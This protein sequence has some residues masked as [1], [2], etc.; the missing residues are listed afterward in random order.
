MN[1][2]PNHDNPMREDPAVVAAVSIREEVSSFN[3][4]VFSRA[5]GIAFIR[6]IIRQAYAAQEE[7]LKALREALAP[8]AAAASH[9]K[10]FGGEAEGNGI[11]CAPDGSM[12]LTVAD[13]QKAK[14]AQ[15]R[16]G[17]S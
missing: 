11:W 7:E 9:M 14:A 4:G 16:G 3:F 8:F 6:D 13:F 12:R 17:E 15:A 1:Q 10:S 5:A 2:P